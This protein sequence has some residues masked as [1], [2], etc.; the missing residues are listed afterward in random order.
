[1][2]KEEA[3]SKKFFTK[4]KIIGIILGILVI[5]SALG[6]GLGLTVFAKEEVIPEVY[7]LGENEGVYVKNISEDFEFKVKSNTGD[8][9]YS[10]YDGNE[11]LI[12][13]KLK[14]LENDEFSI[15][16]PKGD[17]EPGGE[18]ELMLDEGTS[19]VDKNLTEV[20]SIIFKVNRDEVEKVE[21]SKNVVEI[22]VDKL[23]E[24]SQTSVIKLPKANLKENDILLC[25]DKEGNY[26]AYKIIE[27]VSKDSAR[28]ET[29]T[30]DEILSVI[31]INKTYSLSLDDVI[32]DE[33]IEEEIATNV[34]NS[35]FF[36]R[37]IDVAYATGDV[38]DFE[39]LAKVVQ[40]KD[41]EVSYDIEITIKLNPYKGYILGVKTSM[42]P[43]IIK[44]TLENQTFEVSCDI[45]GFRT[46]EVDVKNKSTTKITV[47]FGFEGKLS[48]GIMSQESPEYRNAMKK[49]SERIRNIMAESNDYRIKIFSKK[50]PLPGAPCIV[51]E[52]NANVFLNCEAA[53]NLEFGSVKKNTYTAGISCKDGD[54]KTIVSKDKNE[55]KMSLTTEGKLNVMFGPG[56]E[57]NLFFVSEEIAKIYVNAD[58]GLYFEAIALNSVSIDIKKPIKIDQK[59]SGEFGKCFKLK[60]GAMLN[61]LNGPLDDNITYE[62]RDI[63]KTFGGKVPIAIMAE[64]AV[65][66]DKAIVPP[67]IYLET[68][69]IKTGV[70]KMKEA[71]KK[72]LTYYDSNNK[73][74][75]LI[76]GKLVLS[77]SEKTKNKIIV[78]YKYNGYN[79]KAKIIINNKIIAMNYFEKTIK[80]VINEFG[81]NYT[82]RY[83]N[84][85]NGLTYSENYDNGIP[86]FFNVEAYDQY[87]NGEMQII[88]ESYSSMVSSMLVSKGSYVTEDIIV[89]MT[90][91]QLSKILKKKVKI[92]LNEESELPWIVTDYTWKGNTYMMYFY[93]NENNIIY[94]CHI[95]NHQ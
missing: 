77:E 16:P 88:P 12:P 23:P 57:M 89:G 50:I 33:N 21:Y 25:N 94:E 10:L 83:H 80:D 6:I 37:L 91:A 86:T 44:L 4:K 68:L 61:T 22:E 70:S 55:P 17:Y 42:T 27:L 66:K 2:E 5:V 11:N 62:S 40:S 1:M 90:T 67:V 85:G 58:Y 47:G 41:S 8:V 31:D 45:K 53:A 9:N 15:M 48:N 49:A 32:L 14:S 76:K 79:F 19:F 93:L 46:W 72:Y 65:V 52:L 28:V 29:P 36:K 26:N 73:V 51:I 74:I 64:N 38:K 82:I 39:I 81:E 20:S 56:V 3:T 92:E 34:E 7:Q 69:D 24:I 75:P 43:I 87:Q 60:V 71:N 78:K 95:Q 18:Y 13:I 59:L 84:G 63:I 30:I 54:L 35:E